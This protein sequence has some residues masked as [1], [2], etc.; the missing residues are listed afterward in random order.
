MSDKPEVGFG[1]G[2]EGDQ[3][4][5]ST[6]RALRDELKNVKR[7]QEE[8]ASS[9]EVLHRA[10]DSL[11]KLAEVVA[12]AELA[13]EVFDTAVALGKLSQITGVSTEK[14][15]VYYKAATDVGVAH[16]AVDKGLAKLARSFVQL[17]AGNSGAAS[18]FRLLHLSAK[19][20][21]GLSTDEKLLKVT[22]AFGKM[23]D[24]PEKAAAAIALFGKAGAQLI[25][26]LDQLGGE[27]F[28]KVQAQAER[29]GLIFTQDMAE[30]A[31]RA[32]AALAD[33]K[34]I[35]EGATAQFETGLL[36]ALAETADAM[37]HSI[38]GTTG[39]SNG[40]KTLGELAGKAL[41]FI[42]EGLILLGLD[43]GTTAQQIVEIFSF[44]WDEVKGRRNFGIHGIQTGC[45]RRL[46]GCLEKPAA[47]GSRR[48]T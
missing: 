11:V 42:A 41:K 32:K 16:E 38:T 47:R 31:L 36:P 24:G 34:G 14:L 12:I 27:E 40:F 23:K 10:W 22:N 46:F 7:Q 19:D 28:A 9:A 45:R 5:L 21:V 37:A 17:Q 43:A 33:L 30:G 15:S 44:A 6:L 25:P 4:L 2:V 26:V 18:G 3:S 20:F 35:A 29:L 1:F 39:V 8:T 13:K 48:G